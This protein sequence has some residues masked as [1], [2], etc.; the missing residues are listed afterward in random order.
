MIIFKV[1]TRFL[2]FSASFLGGGGVL[3]KCI[4]EIGGEYNGDID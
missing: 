4:G 2:V 1:I 3:V